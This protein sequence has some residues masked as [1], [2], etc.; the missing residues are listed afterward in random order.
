VQAALLPVAMT[1]V[2]GYAFGWRFKP[3]A[4]LAGDILNVFRL[5]ERHV[6]LYLLD[7]SGHGVAAALL[8]VTVSRFLSPVRDPASLLW[9][10]EE[11]DGSGVTR[12]RLQ[13][14]ARVA[15]R[16]GERFPFDDK[17]G[18]FFTLVYGL[19]DLHTHRLR[20][21]SAGHPGVIH[22]PRGGT[23]RMIEV[24]GYPIGVAPDE[25]DEHEVELAPGDRLYV[26]SDGVPEAMDAADNPFGADRL[27]AQLDQTRSETLDEALGSLLLRIDNWRGG[28]RVHDD[29]S[30]LALE[31]EMERESGPGVS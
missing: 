24:S 27:L 30:V 17:T 18:Q 15:A 1:D 5:D 7:V 28:A 23:T 29:L 6:G 19:L 14:P 8:S 11:A 21:V 25:Y 16:L 9:W 26:Y 4:W 20:Y 22:V 12:Y 10:R 2:P 31:R 3:S 13:P